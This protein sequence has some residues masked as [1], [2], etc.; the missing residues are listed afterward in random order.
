MESYLNMGGINLFVKILVYVKIF[1]SI[2]KDEIFKSLEVQEAS[3]LRL[4]MKETRVSEGIF[5]S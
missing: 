4:K 1:V 3:S 5:I 2:E